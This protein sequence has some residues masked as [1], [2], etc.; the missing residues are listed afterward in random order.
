MLGSRFSSSIS[1]VTGSAYS[2]IVDFQL[3]IADLL[4]YHYRRLRG[5]EIG[6]RQL[7]IGNGSSQKPT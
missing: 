6:N 5:I 7:E 3:P 4:F 2:N 1:L